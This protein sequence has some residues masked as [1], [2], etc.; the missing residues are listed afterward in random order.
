MFAPMVLDIRSGA[1]L[2][3]H[4]GIVDEVGQYLSQRARKA[5]H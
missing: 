2:G 3:M 5:V 4:D 1:C